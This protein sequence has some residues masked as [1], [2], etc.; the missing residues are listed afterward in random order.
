VRETE[1]K[2]GKRVKFNT[3][4]QLERVISALERSIRGTRKTRV[5]YFSP[6]QD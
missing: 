2:D 5:G 3:P 4:E 1:D 6:Q